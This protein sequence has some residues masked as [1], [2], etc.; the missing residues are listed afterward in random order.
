MRAQRAGLCP[1]GLG[2][3][4]P[5]TVADCP[6]GCSWSHG[7]RRVPV[8]P[9]P[10]PPMCLP[11]PHLLQ[12]LLSWTPPDLTSCPSLELFQTAGGGPGPMP[13]GQGSRGGRGLPLHCPPQPLRTSWAPGP[14]PSTTSPRQASRGSPGAGQGA[15]TRGSA[16][17]TPRGDPSTLT[18]GAP[19]GQDAAPRP[20]LRGW[21]HT[22]ELRLR[23]ALLD[24]CVSC[25]SGLEP[26][27]PAGSGAWGQGVG[28]EG[29]P[30]GEQQGEGWAQGQGHPQ[31]PPASPSRPRPPHLQTRPEPHGHRVGVP[32]PRPPPSRPGGPVS[33]G[34]PGYRGQEN[35]QAS[36]SRC[37]GLGPSG[38]ASRGQCLR[39]L[40][41]G[42]PTGGLP[43]TWHLSAPGGSWSGGGHRL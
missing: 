37:L 25:F 36:E 43:P 34:L 2:T 20:G 23:P 1:W 41:C 28:Q 6:P 7:A 18:L 9:T 40:E 29:P 38:T 12:A 31:A 11:N 4:W 27:S 13:R 35:G 5:H 14:E 39:A 15:P 19:G 33:R 42:A 24:C 8:P 16:F 30:A 17:C 3:F 26:G 22:L 32:M 10:G 21:P